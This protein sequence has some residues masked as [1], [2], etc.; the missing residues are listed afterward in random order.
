ME[1][2]FAQI[3]EDGRVTDVRCVEKNYLEKNKELYKGVWIETWR[4]GGHRKNFAVIGSNYDKDNDV[5]IPSKTF[6]SWILDK[7]NWKWIAPVKQPN[8]DK[9][10]FWDEIAI[11]WKEI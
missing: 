8:D 7:V 11:E 9:L 4:N 2:Y 3:N 6:P 5:F 10:Y 1:N